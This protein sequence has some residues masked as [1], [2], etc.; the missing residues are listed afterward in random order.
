M[1]LDGK[2]INRGLLGL[3]R[4]VM[5]SLNNID[6]A[7]PDCYRKSQELEAM[8]IA[9]NAAITFAERH[10]DRARELSHEEEN[11]TRKR[12]LEKIVE[13]CSHVPAH[14]ARNFQEALQS[15]W[16]VHLIALLELNGWSLG[17]GR[18]DLY[19]YPFYQSSLDNKI[20]T[21][22][23][24]KELLE[25]LWVKFNN[26]VAPAK[27]DQAASQSGTYNDFVSFAI[28]GLNEQGLD[29]VNELS[30]LLLDVIKEM[31]LMQPNSAVLISEKTPPKFLLQAAEVIKEGFGQPAV[32]NADLITQELL[33][34]GK[35]LVDAR[36]GALNGCVGANACGK[37]NMAALGYSNWVKVLEITL[38][39]G[40]NPFTGD[41][42][43]LKTG[44]ALEFS[45]FDEVIAAY[46]KQLE[47]FMNIKMKGN[48]LNEMIYAEDMPV[49]FLSI[50]VDDCIKNGKDYHAG[51]ARYNQTI[52]QGVGL[53]TLTDSLVAIKKLV[54]DDKRISL[55][56]LLEAMNK[57][58]KGHERLRQILLNKVPKYGNND[59]YADQIMKK[60]VDIYYEI[61]NGR[62]NSR[63]GTYGI[64]LLPTTVHVYFGSVIG[65]TPDGRNA[66]KPL[67]EGISPAQGAD[68]EG[69]T[70]V[71]K[72]A[73]KMDQGRFC[74]TLLNQKFSPQVLKSPE[75]LNKFSSLIKTYFKLNGHHAQFNVIDAAT[76]KEA[77]TKPEDYRN[78]MVR[79]AG[80]SD[81]FVNLSKALQNE[82]ISRTEQKF[83]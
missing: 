78:L 55:D 35:S 34:K 44:K 80:Y 45:N 8:K 52:I 20:I 9:I 26:T 11:P 58:F 56:N 32:F 15:Y 53:G 47:Y 18:F 23:D 6:Y 49:P 70:S 77:Q 19:M 27:E 79:V 61:V 24:A 60:V 51:G 40:T 4:E 41:Q 82:I 14:P 59:D 22:E 42:I 63:G 10:A 72:S 68:R 31:K 33:H 66:G 76:L 29:A 5:D 46:K 36:L 57:D 7:S 54:F 64:T 16:F 28:G 81:Y 38:N 48:N 67:S 69:P 73:S 2:V 37:E 71:F 3:K 50:L 13:I 83:I 30:Y 65:A 1:T 17:A 75:D 25:C 43:G 21:K 12:E 62:P 74:G 39:N